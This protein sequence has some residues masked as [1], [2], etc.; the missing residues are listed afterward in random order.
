M[1]RPSF[2]LASCALLATLGGAWAGCYQSGSDCSLLLTCPVLECSDGVKDGSETDVDCGG[3]LC[4]PCVQGKSCLAG[5]DCKSGLFCADAFCCDSACG[6]G[7]S[8]AACDIPDRQGTCT[9]LPAGADGVTCNGAD[10]CNGDGACVGAGSAGHLGDLCA[11]N[12]ACFNDTCQA[13]VCKL[14]DGDPCAEDAACRTGR[15]LAGVCT[16][17]AAGADCASGAC[18]PGGACLLVGGV[19]CA[20]GADCASSSCSFDH[21]CIQQGSAPCVPTQC[22]THFCSEGLCSTCMP[23]DACTGGTSCVGSM[24]L[25]PSGAYCTSSADCASD[26]CEPAGLLSLRKCK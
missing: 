5:S 7:E 16:T 18:G 1:R 11:S 15:C 8:C 22:L 9:D 24:C 23:G 21:Y 4:P 3:P 14:A 2:L 12:A 10:T 6:A 17:C 13:G 25:A 26:T 19:P 20:T